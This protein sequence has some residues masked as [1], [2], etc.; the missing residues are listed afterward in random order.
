MSQ[1]L[2]KKLAFSLV[3]IKT[4]YQRGW[5]RDL[6]WVSVCLLSPALAYRAVYSLTLCVL[7]K[8]EYPGFSWIYFKVNPIIMFSFIA[9]RVWFR[10]CSVCM[11]VWFLL[12]PL[13]PSCLLSFFNQCGLLPVN[14]VWF[15]R[16]ICHR[17]TASASSTLDWL[18]NTS[19]AGRIGVTTRGRDSELYTTTF[20]DLKEWV[21]ESHLH[22]HLTIWCISTLA[23]E[24][25]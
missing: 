8:R 16:E 15:Y 24:I 18:L 11:T 14:T 10:F 3:K 20:L 23:S 21:N 12:Y 5:K 4:H 19:W 6:A 7:S 25:F 17:T 1:N 13:F 22:Y 2:K 9:K